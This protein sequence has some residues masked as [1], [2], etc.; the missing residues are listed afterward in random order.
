MGRET[1]AEA[2][3]R[4]HDGLRRCPRL[5]AEQTRER[6]APRIGRQALRRG[7]QRFAPRR[8]PPR[9]PPRVARRKRKSGVLPNE[10]VA[11]SVWNES[12]SNDSLPDEEKPRCPGPWP[13]REGW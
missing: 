11:D 5:P 10:R 1:S 12:V 7:T 3:R 9:L 6:A 13:P 8:L 4:L 2:A